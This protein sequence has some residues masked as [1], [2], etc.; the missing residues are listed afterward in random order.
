MRTSVV[1][2]NFNLSLLDQSGNPISD[3]STFYGFDAHLSLEGIKAGQYSLM[4]GQGTEATLGQYSL[5]ITSC[6]DDQ[7]K[8]D[9]FESNNTTST[10]TV[11]NDIS[12]IDSLDDLTLTNQ[13]D[14]DWY[15]FTLVGDQAESSFIQI[16]N[17][18]ADDRRL[19]ELYDST[20]TTPID[21]TLPS[22]QDGKLMIGNLIGGGLFAQNYR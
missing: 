16:N 11:L 4:I 5:A 18:L 12:S 3:Q 14:V 17:E 6:D 7:H 8:E 21:S 10:A 19:I 22:S 13:S 20:G 9:R 2:R 15:Q 1:R